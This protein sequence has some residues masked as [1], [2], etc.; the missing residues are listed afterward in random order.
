MGVLSILLIFYTLTSWLLGSTIIGWTSL[1]TI[2]L[3]IG[4]VQLLVL[5]AIGEYLGRLYVEA[6]R[7]PL[8]IIESVCSAASLTVPASGDTERPHYRVG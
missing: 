7:R 5:G 6:K 8:F 2:V 3:V 1:T 4:S